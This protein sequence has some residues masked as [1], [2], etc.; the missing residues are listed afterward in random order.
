MFKSFAT[1]CCLGLLVTMVGAHPNKQRTENLSA[2]T[3]TPAS[4]AD[5]QRRQALR[6]ALVSQRD[7]TDQSNY[8]ARAERHLTH[9]E[10]ALL[11]QQL[12]Q[13]GR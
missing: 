8:T 1:C 9:H 7:G 10:R 12:R 13:Q 11:R 6:A 4:D 3:S 5:V 2:A